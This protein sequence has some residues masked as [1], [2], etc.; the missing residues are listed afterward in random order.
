[1]VRFYSLVGGKRMPG[2]VLLYFCMLVNARG[3]DF[4][5]LGRGVI[6]HVTFYG[7]SWHLIPVLLVA[8]DF[9]ARHW[10]V[11]LSVWSI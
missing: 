8:Q 7:M 3:C 1:M 10:Y 11:V 4:F 2:E 5:F 6:L 9:Y